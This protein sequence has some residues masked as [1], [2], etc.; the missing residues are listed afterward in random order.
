[1]LG[2]VVAIEG[3]RMSVI[4]P[5]LKKPLAWGRKSTPTNKGAQDAHPWLVERLLGSSGEGLCERDHA[6]GHGPMSVC[7]WT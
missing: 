6:G 1:M 7:G 2:P 3:I 4:V 5:V